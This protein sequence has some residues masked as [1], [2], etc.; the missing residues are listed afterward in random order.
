M[1]FY[2]PGDRHRMRSFDGTVTLI[3]GRFSMVEEAVMG[4]AT[5]S[6]WYCYTGSAKSF[7]LL[8]QSAKA[9]IFKYS[10]SEWLACY[11]WTV[12]AIVYR[13]EL[14]LGVCI[15][16]SVF[17]ELYETYGF[18]RCV[19]NMIM[20]SVYFWFHRT[21]FPSFRVGYFLLDSK[22]T[23]AAAPDGSWEML[24]SASSK[25][26]GKDLCSNVALQPR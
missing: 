13:A 24:P 19:T 14:F 5:N 17:F 10:R 8:Y 12:A 6:K 21:Q 3:T 20:P 7:V 23:T 11:C 1:L 22:P 25:K 9:E 18:L 2:A 26:L 15:V 16:K 4:N